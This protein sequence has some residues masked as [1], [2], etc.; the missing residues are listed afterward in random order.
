MAQH[1]GITLAANN[2]AGQ[3]IAIISLGGPLDKSELLADL[4]AL[5]VNLHPENL[6]IKHVST[7][8]TA[9]GAGE[10]HLDLEVIGSICPAAK[11]T[12]YRAPNNF[13]QGFEPA[14]VRAVDD[15][16]KVISIS[17]GGSEN[18]GFE[19]SPFGAAF[20]YAA[21]NSVTVTVATGD[22]GSANSRYG[23]QAIGARDGRAHVQMPGV[24][25]WVL[26]CG[27]SELLSDGSE[28]VWNNADRGGG[29]TGGGVSDYIPR[30]SYQEGLNFT[31]V[32]SGFQGRAFSGKGPIGFLND[33]LYALAVKD[34]CQFRAV[35]HGTNSPYPGYP[36]YSAGPGFD[37][38]CG[39][40]SPASG[41]H[42]INT[43]AQLPD[44]DPSWFDTVK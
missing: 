13:A 19:S 24:S 27:G 18:Q 26:A 41:D 17:W 25:P 33:H 21:K 4:A 16:N 44:R 29:A 35:N 39:W 2:G 12:I 43:L 11:I 20:V 23:N 37:P 28:Q 15:G 1:Y 40:G 7:P 42:L 9:G 30:P 22:G 8:S 10:T 6:D 34:P 31:S 38:C 32:N 3:S 5:G 14:V 36:G